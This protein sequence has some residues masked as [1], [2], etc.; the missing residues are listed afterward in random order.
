MS[1]KNPQSVAP[2]LVGAELDV[3]E[4]A[5][6]EVKDTAPAGAQT[7]KPNALARQWARYFTKEGVHSYDEISWETR[8]AVITNE[9]GKK[10][11]EQSD[12]EVPS[13]Y[14]QSATNIVVS[15]YF[16]GQIG[17]P[18]RERSV[19]H[20]VDRV[21][22]TITGWGVEGGYFSNEDAQVF[23]E[24][25]T[26]LLV[27]Q[28]A[29]FN[30]PVWFN[31]GVKDHPQCSACFILSIEDSM[32]SILDWI[33][34]EGI[35]F[36]GGS[37]SGI[38]LSTLRS[39]KEPLTTAGT[40]SGPVS[41]MRGADASAGA[42]KSGGATRRA[43]KMVILNADHPDIMEFV[44][45]KAR[46]EKK[47]WALGE[48]GYDLSLNGEAWK[49][50]Q[51]QNANNSVRVTDEFMRI[52]EAGGQWSTHAVRTGEV[53]ET[54][55]AQ[56]L[57]D[58]IAQAA[59][60][61][62][63][64]GMQF[65]TVINDWHTCSNTGR[66][67]GSNPC[68][69]YMHLDNSAC[70]L[71]SINIMRFV[72]MDS[73]QFDV[74]GFKKAVDVMF[75]AQEI[76]VGF[77]SYPTPEIEKNAHAFRELGLGYAN[78]GAYL[79]L[80]GLPYDSDEGR[81]M[82]ANIT[83]IMTGEAYAQSARIA[84]RVGP[85]SGYE[86]NKDPMLR[87]IR[88]HWHKA[89]EIPEYA[90]TSN[91]KYESVKTWEL[92]YRLGEQHGYRN[93]QA[94]VLA[95]TGTISFL[96]DC[97]TTGI[98][99]DIAL[100][101]YK[102]LVGGGLMKLVNQTVPKALKNLGYSDKERATILEY[103]ERQDTIEGAPGFRPEHLAVFDCAFKPQN[104]TRSISYMGHIR[105]MGAVQPFISGAISKTVNL[106]TDCTPADIAH[107][108]KEAWKLGVKAIA[109]Y[110][111]GSKR[112]QPLTT[113]SRTENSLAGSQNSSSQPVPQE[114]KP[115]RRRLSDE[116]QSI[117][118][119]FSIANH[120][121]YITVGLYD[122][123]KP[124]E[125]FITMAKEGSVISGLM[126]SFATSISIALQYG[127][128]LKVMANKF[129]HARFEPSGFTNH[130]KIRVAKSLVDYI[131]RWMA[132]KFLS[133]DDQ[134]QIGF[135]PTELE[136]PSGD[137]QFVPT[138][139]ESQVAV[140]ASLPKIAGDPYVPSPLPASP[141]NGLSAIAHVSTTMFTFDSQSDA[142]PCDT[143]GSIMVRNAACYKCLNCGNTSGCS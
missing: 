34:V 136:D 85:F 91:L 66:I 43:A 9:K 21:A 139:V 88:K 19:K 125:I 24:E 127:V 95:P 83:A 78:L 20:M 36:K 31:V 135:N 126:D 86:V 87:V 132:L 123:G 98:E 124:G 52:L 54:F 102:V 15:K 11:F 120:E 40:A 137:E 16:R 122:D 108:Y 68:S 39:S 130:P 104:G 73:G 14:S 22:K 23:E 74:E 92:A 61:C 69:E 25:L 117:T 141:L 101:K 47:A 46:E 37:G 112:T 33:R 75:T 107:T 99:P 80:L 142:P 143:C 77:S 105:M 81:A 51:F 29:A 48:M 67:N 28:K 7:T 140:Q 134:T 53:L 133:A 97:D 138:S 35:I 18:Q 119:K 121:G 90:F 12:I 49:S 64:P 4:T 131:F 71:A 50:I 44:E 94:T 72:D 84:E 113:T 57:M 45:C 115:L 93:S 8:S 58:A 13:F 89:T 96:M 41:F 62:G 109:I 60:V 82:A 17:T 100:V 70:N 79:M 128:P 55:P 6:R 27:H 2:S 10:I 56:Q 106:P 65:D 5:V 76:I 1:P 63:D 3:K 32:A 111:D 103:I 110:R 38:N 118:H 30:S 42:I 26:H 129:V 114:Y 59:W 116:R